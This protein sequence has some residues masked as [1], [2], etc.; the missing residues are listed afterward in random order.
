MCK[1]RLVILHNF[2]G[3]G[4]GNS[5]VAAY[6][7]IRDTSFKSLFPVFEILNKL[8]EF[9]KYQFFLL[10]RIVPREELFENSF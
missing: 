9:S 5:V 8:T 3:D 1:E 2:N 7:L 10:T 4:E 6:F